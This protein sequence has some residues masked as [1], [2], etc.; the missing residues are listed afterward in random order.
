MRIKKEIT[1][2]DECGEEIQK[3]KKKNNEYIDEIQRGCRRVGIDLCDSCA[4]DIKNKMA[5][6]KE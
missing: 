1:Y 5:I 6:I 2:C 4:E 3:I